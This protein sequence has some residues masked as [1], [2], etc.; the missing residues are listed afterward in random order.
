M[1]QKLVEDGLALIVRAMFR[2][3]EAGRHDDAIATGEA[4]ISV[5]RGLVLD[6]RRLQFKKQVERENERQARS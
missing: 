1:T 2:D 4:A 6:V 3:S 5:I